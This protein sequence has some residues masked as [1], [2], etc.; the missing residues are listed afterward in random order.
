MPRALFFFS[1]LLVTAGQPGQVVAG[2]ST[3]HKFGEFSVTVAADP[4]ATLTAADYQ[5]VVENTELLVARLT[6]PYH[7]TLSNSFVADLDHDGGFEVVVT[8]SEASGHETGIKV[9]TWKDNLLQPV[10][11][12]E[13]DASQ[14]QGHRGND[15]FAIIDAKLVRTFQI[16]EQ[17]NGTWS[18]TAT[19]RQLRYSFEHARWTSDQP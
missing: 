6:A 10:K 8:Y 1:V 13:L 15:E 17:Q 7:G 14:S 18:A 16:Y 19:R 11:L 9:Y 4:S 5:I 2:N 3:Q 12:A